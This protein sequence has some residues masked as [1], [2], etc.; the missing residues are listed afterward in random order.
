[1]DFHCILKMSRPIRIGDWVLI[2]NYHYIIRH[3]SPEGIYISSEHEPQSM[4]LL[5]Q[6]GRRSKWQVYQYHVPHTVT[7]KAATVDNYSNL[8]FEIIMKT[9]LSLNQE[10]IE[11][12]CLT[13]STFNQVICNN[14]YFWQ[15]KFL[16]DYN[17]Q[18]IF[19]FSSWKELYRGYQIY[20]FGA[21]SYG[22]LGVRD[23]HDKDI[24]TK[25]PKIKAQQ[26]SA[27]VSHSLIL[28]L[29]GNV[30][31]FGLNERGQLGLGDNRYTRNVPT[32]I[33]GIKAQQVSVGQHHSLIVDLEGNVC[34]FGCDIY[35][36]LGLAETLNDQYTNL[37]MK[38][39]DIKARQVSA[40]WSHSLL[41]D[42]EGNVWAFGNNTYGQLGLS[43]TL[44]R[45]TPA[46]IPGIKAR[47]V[48]AGMHYSL[49][50]DLEGNVWAFGSNTSGQLGLQE[51]DDI[52]IPTMIPEIKARQVS[53]GGYHSLIVDLEGNVWA[54]GNN[55]YGQLGL[56]DT[57]MRNTPTKVPR[58]KAKQVSAGVD[59]SLILD[60]TNNIWSF[61]HNKYGQLGLQD[62]L[63]REF[64]LLIL[65][66]KARQV[67][68]GFLYSL[69]VGYKPNS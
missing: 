46:R 30:W 44:M 21:N 43:D 53:A 34:A 47:Q 12:L 9:A 6:S 39:P 20:A 26:V 55:K 63:N 23:F 60:E 59:H 18:P 16:Q 40:G 50:V 35:G 37:P 1:M 62:D 48:S 7:F 19:D 64:P 36:Q 41:L 13:S 45:N 68:A 27:G 56:S 38:I 29:E 54:F 8:P 11:N 67:S 42:P 32:M 2:N 5:V 3:L 66:I 28:D 58:I 69:I 22:N 51:Y 57:L 24:P 25:I 31:A 61:G 33:P 10:S 14:D 4:S 65:G 15:L 49:I 52:N 17:Y